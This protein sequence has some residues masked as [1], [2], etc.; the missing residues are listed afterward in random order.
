MD[1]DVNKQLEEK[2]KDSSINNDMRER[3]RQYNNRT[4]FLKTTQESQWGQ[5]MR[6]PLVYRRSLTFDST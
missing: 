6:D 2:R 1:A 5:K 3:E 4:R